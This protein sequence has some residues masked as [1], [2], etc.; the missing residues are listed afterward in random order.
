MY[1]RNTLNYEYPE[2]S[3]EHMITVEHL[4]DTNFDVN[5]PY[6]DK[7]LGF[8]LVRGFYWV[9]V[10]G[11]VFPLL[12]LT[13]GLRI[14][15]KENIKK[16]KKYLKDGAITISNHVFYWDFLCVLRAMRPHLAFFPAWKTNFEGP[17]RHLIRMSGGIPIPTHDIHA[18][19]KF[20]HA[21]EEVLEEGRC[22]HFFPEGSMWLYYPDIRPFKKA[23]FTYAVKYDKPIIP[24]TLSFR[25]R[26]GITKLFTNKP[27]VDL[28]VGEAMFHDKTLS[29]KLAEEELQA[30]AYHIMQTMNGINPG[31]P[32]YNTDQNIDHYKK[33]M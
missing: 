11:V 22:L 20:K 32:T 2:R 17:N 5:F 26:R 14:Y 13:H 1:Y 21:I 25:P 10:N 18:M 16:N 29:P 24:I 4:C 15:D 33:T 12:R 6:R 23:V 28:H 19:I 31:D 30:R 27:C 9:M 8:K 3:D 7:S